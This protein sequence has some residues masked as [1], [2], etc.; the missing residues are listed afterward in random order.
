MIRPLIKI[1][2]WTWLRIKYW[3]TKMKLIKELNVR[4]NEEIYL[5]ILEEYENLLRAERKRL[6][7]PQEVMRYNTIIKTLKWVV[8]KQE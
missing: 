7:D 3:L 1:R 5:R 6:I 2:K 4:T 8:N